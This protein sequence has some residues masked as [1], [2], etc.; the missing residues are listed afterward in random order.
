LLVKS[1]GLGLFDTFGFPL[2]LPDAK[3]AESR[4]KSARRLREI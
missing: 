4:V 1:D 2:T 3:R